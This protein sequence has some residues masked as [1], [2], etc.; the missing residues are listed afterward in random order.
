MIE[1]MSLVRLYGETKT[2]DQVLLN[3]MGSGQFHPE[4]PAQLAGNVG[5]FALL[6]EEN[7]YKPMLATAR[8]IVGAAGLKAADF[9]EQGDGEETDGEETEQEKSLKKEALDLLLDFANKTENYTQL[10]EKLQSFSSEFEKL[11]ACKYLKI[12]FGRLPAESFAKLDQFSGEKFHFFSLTSDQHYHWGF[13]V[14]TEEAVAEV[15]DIFAA[16][17][18]H[19]EGKEGG[20]TL[21][22]EEN[23]YRLILANM[24]EVAEMAELELE[25]TAHEALDKSAAEELDK[26][27][28]TFR[29]ELMTLANRRKQLEDLAAKSRES[30]TILDRLNTLD[31][32]FD[33][34]FDWEY[35]KIRFGRLPV[36]S[37]AKLDYYADKLFLFF[38][39]SND[40]RYHWGFF[41]TTP[42]AMAEVEDIFAALYFE[43]V[44]IPDTIRGKP[45]AAR[46]T[47]ENDLSQMKNEIADLDQKISALV[48]ENKAFFLRAYVTLDQLNRSFEMRKYVGVY[49]ESFLLT[50][51]IPKREEANFAS[52]FMGVHNLTLTFQPHDSDKRLQTPTK[53]RN[54]WFCKPFEMFV[55][56]YG[57]PGYNEL[58]PTAFLAVTYTLL[59]GVMFGDLGQGAAIAGLGLLLWRMKRMPFGK[60]LMRIGACSS[61]FGL[62]YGSVFGLEDVLDPLYRALGF[63]SKPVHIMEP[64]TINNL[65]MVAV[66]AG[67]VLIIISMILNIITGVR[68]GDLER[69]VFSNNGLAGLVFYGGILAGIVSMLAGGPN[70]FTAPY[71]AGFIVLPVLVIFFKESL[72]RLVEKTGGFLPENDGV[73][74]FAVEGFFELFEVVLSFVTN[75]LSFLRVGGFVVSHAGMMGVVLTL[76]E[77]SR[78]TGSV[79]VL[80]VGNVFV[81]ALEGF[82]VGIQI[83]RLEFYELFSHCFEGQGKPYS[84]IGSNSQ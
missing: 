25:L 81:I 82:I 69:A 37:F 28:L 79:L 41:V 43:R 12:R 13:F 6:S 22:S 64:V 39:L 14:T 23:P 61:L 1:E 31:A 63:A 72:G 68:N 44:W 84:P 45:E 17:S 50:G 54:N 26:F 3:C 83:L 47:V 35:V 20:F 34:L 78:S 49:R 2:L 71:I 33:E 51:F 24:R 52:L 21:L 9:L 30:L 75:T 48:Q 74:S 80:I 7:P 53:L 18:F 16:L 70:L 67:A 5:G 4:H 77:M 59:F 62:L 60:I 66:G 38:S 8:E 46:H 36:D 73:G 27:I 40:K 55:D 32:N 76:S 11:F 56:M 15:E 10:I 29:E 42:E 58:D 65:L 57:T 19:M